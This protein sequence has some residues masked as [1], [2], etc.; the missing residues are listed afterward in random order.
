MKVSMSV[1][2]QFGNYRSFSLRRFEGMADFAEE[3]TEELAGSIKV[4]SGFGVSF[5]DFNF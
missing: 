5:K 4:A 1:F 2:L 3:F